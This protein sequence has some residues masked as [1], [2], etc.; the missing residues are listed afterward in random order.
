MRKGDVFLVVF[1]SFLVAHGEARGEGTCKNRSKHGVKVVVKIKLYVY[2]PFS[3]WP[4]KIVSFYNKKQYIFQA[5]I[6]NEKS[7]RSRNSY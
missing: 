5:G 2:L 1:E 3:S 4:S 6:D 7:Q